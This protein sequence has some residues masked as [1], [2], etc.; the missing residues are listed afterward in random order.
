MRKNL[1]LTIFFLISILKL[2]AQTISYYP[3][4]SQLAVS[5]KNSS[6]IFLE[7][8]VQMN[9]ATSLITTEIGPQILL[10]KKN[11][12][13]FYLGGGAS[14][15]WFNDIFIKQS[16][17]L[18]GYYGSLGVRSYPFE[19]LNKLGL[20]FEITPYTDANFTTGLMRAWLGVSYKF[21]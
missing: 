4:N 10:S 18:K 13:F 15:G 7:A 8:R 11:N 1:L 12:S 17:N 14:I 5:T 16:S 20:N 21:K 19:K 6:P 2:N 3:F 9:S